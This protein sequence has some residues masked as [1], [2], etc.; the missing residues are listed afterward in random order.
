MHNRIKYK[1]L[2]N[3][4]DKLRGTNP[5]RNITLLDLGV[6]RANDVN[7]WNRLKIN[8]IVGID[9]SVQQLNEA[10][11]RLAKNTNVKLI[12]L[13]LAKMSDVTSLKD[14]L[15]AY[16]FDII[17]AF[18]SIHYFIDNLNLILKLINKSSDCIF[19]SVYMNLKT[20]IYLF[21]PYFE[22][23]YIYIKRIDDK[24]IEVKFSDTPYFINLISR[25]IVIDTCM[26]EK[27]L[28]TLFSKPITESFIKYYKNI[29]M[30]PDDYL[31]VEL[32]H[33]TL[34]AELTSN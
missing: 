19:L 17:C 27:Q 3:A 20:H 29:N 12:K 6:G 22:N 13:N 1:L 18:Y 2:E 30:L 10:K 14:E 26:I 7:K 34:I 11:A 24:Y 25:E 32:M 15:A 5:N 8:N 33:M 28:S 31:T 4:I 9:S 16:S 21:A 23:N